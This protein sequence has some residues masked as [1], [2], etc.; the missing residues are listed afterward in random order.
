MTFLR[1]MF[2]PWRSV[3]ED[4]SAKLYGVYAIPSTLTFK[5]GQLARRTDG[6]WA[7]PVMEKQLL[8][9]VL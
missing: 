8:N 9:G 7:M 5:N 6:N 1:V 2:Q 4:P 3:G